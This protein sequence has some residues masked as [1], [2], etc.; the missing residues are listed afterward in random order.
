MTKLFI[1]TDNLLQLLQQG[2]QVSVVATTF[3]VKT[4]QA[5]QKGSKTIFEI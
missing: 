1:N 5:P 3:F 4:L 2:F